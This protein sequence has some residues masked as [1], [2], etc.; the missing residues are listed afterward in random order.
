MWV[1]KY[2]EL[3]RELRA[4][5]VKGIQGTVHR[6]P[7]S[8]MILNNLVRI[9][10]RYIEIKGNRDSTPLSKSLQRCSSAQWMWRW[11][12][13]QWPRRSRGHRHHTGKK[14]IF[15]WSKTAIKSVAADKT[16]PEMIS[17]L[18]RRFDSLV[19]CSLNCGG[20]L[21]LLFF[22]CNTIANWIAVVKAQ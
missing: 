15:R 5:S 2:K 8:A 17:H 21:L 1:Q 22:F 11:A 19:S 7:I 6:I 14:K 4:D 12:R 13:W 20:M 16:T 3:M 18:H 10:L 9:C